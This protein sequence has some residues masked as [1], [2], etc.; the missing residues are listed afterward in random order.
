MTLGEKL[1]VLR[2]SKGMSQEQ[3]A[4]QITVSRQAI[5]KWE[6]GESKPDI[7]NIIQIS[8]IFAVTTDY[9]LKDDEQ[10]NG[11]GKN[12][13]QSNK[14]TAQILL[15]ASVAFLAIG[16]LSAFGGWYA[17]QSTESIWGG[18]I[19]QVVGV[20]AYCIGR[21]FLQSKAPLIVILMNLA[22]GIFMPISMVSCALYGKV[23]SPYPSDIYSAALFIVVYI[24]AMFISFIILKKRK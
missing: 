20:V 16:L 2:K 11:N 7:E 24:I 4:A 23:I 1:Q 10:S 19:I 5:S 22:F 8:N 12:T 3:F 9:L 21:V 18:M 14:I 6:L 13:S 15:I 17:D